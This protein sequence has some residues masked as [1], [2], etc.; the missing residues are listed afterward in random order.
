MATHAN[1]QAVKSLNKSSG[2]NFVVSNF[3]CLYSL[4]DLWLCTMQKFVIINRYLWFLLLFSIFNCMWIDYWYLCSMQFK[5][6]AT[7]T[8]GNQHW[9][10]PKSRPGESWTLGRLSFFH[11][12][13]VEYRVCSFISSFTIS[14]ESFGH[15]FMILELT[16]KSWT[17]LRILYH[18]IDIQ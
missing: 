8:W 16:H 10:V 12:C 4:C 5:T 3:V 13:L 18:F 6:F 15:Y 7:N 9:C 11:D 2:P 17:L 14:V 1:T